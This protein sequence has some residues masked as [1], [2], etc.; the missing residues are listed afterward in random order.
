MKKNALR[1]LFS[2]YLLSF[3]SA[4]FCRGGTAF[5]PELALA[6]ISAPVKKGEPAS[7]SARFHKRFP[8]LFTGM[9]IEIATS[10]YPIDK[11]NPVFR[12]FGNVFYEKLPEGGYSYLIMANFSSKD[13]ALEFTQKVVKPKVEKARLIQFNEGIRKAIRE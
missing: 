8:Q 9:A 10:T 3:S 7:S 4:G 5:E 6:A 12:Q 1:T 13:A 11:A 2:L